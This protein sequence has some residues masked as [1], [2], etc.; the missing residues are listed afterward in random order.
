MST[1]FKQLVNLKIVSSFKSLVSE[2]KYLRVIFEKSQAIGFIPSNGKHVKTDLPS[3]WVFES[4][5]GELFLEGFDEGPPHMLHVIELLKLISLFLRTI[6]S[7]GG[8]IHHS[9]SVLNEGPSFDGDIEV[10]NIVQ[11]KVN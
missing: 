2:K 5:I 6:P 9:R 3:N 1:P 4:N 10:G 7:D 11:A 8:Y